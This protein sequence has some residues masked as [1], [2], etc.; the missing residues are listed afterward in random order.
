MPTPILR[1]H[2]V[3]SAASVLALGPNFVLRLLAIRGWYELLFIFLLLLIVEVTSSRVQRPF[4]LTPHPFWIPVHWIS[5][6]Y[7]EVVCL[8]RGSS[9][10]LVG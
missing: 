1:S 2:H 9:S 10:F 4:C 7:G 8:L 6:Q 3:R 5:V